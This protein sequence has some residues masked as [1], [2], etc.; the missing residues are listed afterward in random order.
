MT[1]RS[2]G[3]FPDGLIKVSFREVD[4]VFLRRI[5]DPRAFPALADILGMSS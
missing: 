4:Y 3:D 1:T 2:R 5:A